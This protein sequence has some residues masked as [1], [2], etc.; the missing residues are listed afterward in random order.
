MFNTKL[1]GEVLKHDLGYL[2]TDLRMIEDQEAYVRD[3]MKDQVVPTTK[4]IHSKPN[5]NRKILEGRFR[6]FPN[7]T[8]TAK[9]TLRHI[10]EEEANGDKEAKIRPNL[11]LPRR[12]TGAIQL[13]D[14]LRLQCLKQEIFSDFKDLDRS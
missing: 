6:L 2:R 8:V 12:V 7:A 1:K 10:L 3:S 14:V 4:K 11:K 5:F 13:E 9:R